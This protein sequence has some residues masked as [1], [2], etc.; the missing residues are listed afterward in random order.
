MALELVIDGWAD[1]QP[2]AARFTCDGEDVS[3]AVAWRG[4]PAGAKTLVLALVDPD[5]PGGTFVHWLLFNLPASAQGLGE[6]VA[7]LP[8]GTQEGTTDFGRLGYGGPCPP[9]GKPHRYVF[10][11]FALD[12]PLRLGEGVA[13]R[14]VTKAMQD[15]VL[16][17]TQAVGSYERGGRHRD[18]GAAAEARR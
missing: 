18:A 3:P 1:A 15:H 16:G 10:E 7:A 17:Q 9:R 4:V 5:A 8:A 12:T 14:H 13:Y 6:G 11:L 2:V